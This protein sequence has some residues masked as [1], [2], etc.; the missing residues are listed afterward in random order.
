VQNTVEAKPGTYITGWCASG[1]HQDKDVLT[2]SGSLLKRCQGDFIFPRLEKPNVLCNCTCHD[3]WRQLKALQAQYA[4]DTPSMLIGSTPRP[5][6]ATSGDVTPLKIHAV[7]PVLDF[8]M[9]GIVPPVVQNIYDLLYDDPHLNDH[10]ARILE[11]Y[12]KVQR[13]GVS[14]DIVGFTRPQGSLGVNIETV[15]RLI[16]DGI[17]PKIGNVTASYIAL[18][19]D[20]DH[21]ISEGAIRNVL[22][23]YKS[24]GFMDVNDNPLYFMNFKGNAITTPI[25]KLTAMIKRAGERPRT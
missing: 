4:T 21:P 20:P 3:V 12:C 23:K 19:A 15:C 16:T 9:Y 22:M 24:E 25:S 8:P 5:I 13:R 11:K 17:V 1:G 7:T 10:M 14:R 18:L 6:T 2:K